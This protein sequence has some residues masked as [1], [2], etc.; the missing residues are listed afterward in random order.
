MIL[1]KLR[2]VALKFDRNNHKHNGKSRLLL[3]ER[4]PD[5][6]TRC[7]LAVADDVFVTMKISVALGVLLS[8]AAVASA[9]MNVQKC[10]IEWCLDNKKHKAMVN[11]K[12]HC[13]LDW[14]HQYM[15]IETVT[16]KDGRVIDRCYCRIF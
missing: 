2:F 5:Y 13:C 12:L 11:G 4:I 10:R 14:V 7:R 6:L 1:T 9:S 15:T 8:A 3:A 16:L